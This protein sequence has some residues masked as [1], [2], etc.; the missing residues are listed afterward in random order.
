MSER[1][2]SLVHTHTKTEDVSGTSRDSVLTV[3]KAINQTV[4]GLIPTLKHVALTTKNIAFLYGRKMSDD[5][6]QLQ[7]ED[8]ALASIPLSIEA[9]S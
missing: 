6:R 9:H 2:S 7:Q 3:Q 8:A 4:S 5:F 1:D